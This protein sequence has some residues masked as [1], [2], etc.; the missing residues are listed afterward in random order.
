ME[1]N[2]YGRIKM[3]VE[4]SDEQSEKSGGQFL[5][6]FVEDN[7]QVLDEKYTDEESTNLTLHEQNFI[8]MLIKYGKG[9]ID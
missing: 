9:K 4:T 5:L 1:A 6:D 8:H 7:Q 3:L 2:D